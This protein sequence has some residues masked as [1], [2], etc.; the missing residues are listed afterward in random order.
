MNNIFK[1][2]WWKIIGVII[3]LVVI[4][5]GLGIPLN[6]GITDVQP[7]ALNIGEQVSL[8][9]NAYNSDFTKSNN[10]ITSY[11]KSKSSFIK[12]DSVYVMNE[13]SIG[14]MYTIPYEL[15]GNSLS[16]QSMDLIVIDPY[17]GT[18]TQRNSIQ[19]QNNNIEALDMANAKSA[20]K[21]IVLSSK[22]FGF[23]NREILQES[24]RN[25]FFHVPMWFGM[26]FMLLFSFITSILYLSKNNLKYDT[27]AASGAEGGLL[28]G[29][30]GICTGMLWAN[31]TWGSPWPSDAKLD[32][33]AIAMLI[34][35]AYAILRKSIE[36]PIRKAKVSAV[37]NVFAFFIY[38]AFI[39]VYPRLKDSLHPGNGGN[40]A[41]SNTDLDNRMRM[42][43]YPAVIGWTIL[44]FWLV[45]LKIRYKFT[46]LKQQ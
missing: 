2:W 28:Y 29:I 11:L 37:Y 10:Q 41:F 24:I 45:S 31:Y 34:Y 7:Q 25:L 38:L 26:V 43:F 17:N 8:Q 19:V 42:L 3:L 35:I 33:A 13:Y 39:F 27:Y 12:A 46:L 14:A 32:G 1:Q 5:A 40:P 4:I 18:L 9:I 30:L 21:P 6:P 44:G 15:D 16:N 36:D 22:N 23:P 20:V